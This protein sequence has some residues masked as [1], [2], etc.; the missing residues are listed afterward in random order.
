MKVRLLIGSICLSLFGVLNGQ[1]VIEEAEYFIDTDPGQGNGTAIA[2]PEPNESPVDFSFE[3]PAGEI[4][5][6]DE[7]QHTIGIRFKDDDGEWSVAKFKAFYKQADRAETPDIVAA[8]YYFDTDPGQGNGTPITV[9]TAAPSQEI[10]FD[11]P[12]ETIAALDLGFHKLVI[13]FQDGEGDWSVAMVRTINRV[14]PLSAE[15]TDPKVA[16][17]DYQWLVDGEE[18]GDEQSLTPDEPAKVIAF[19]ELLDLKDLD[20]VT[21]VLRMTPFDTAG[22]MGHPAFHTM[23]IEWLDEENEGAGDGLP[24]AWEDQ[25]EELD[26]TVVNDKNADS[27]NDGLTD[28]EEF[29]A[30]T[31][32]GEPDTD[33]DGINDYSEVILAAYGFD[34]TAD[35]SDL[36]AELQDAAVGA[37]LF[38]TEVQLRDININAPIVARDLAT[39]KI[40]LQIRIQRSSALEETDWTQLPVGSADVAT[41]GGDIKVTLPDQGDDIYFL[42][43]FTDE[44]F[45]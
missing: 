26:S 8:E 34:P 30:G 24:D 18:V 10:S 11:I 29:L 20:G 3:I 19:N 39:G 16:R 32:P 33:A 12:V 37:G 4:D 38:S 7:G 15:Q 14:E 27:D 6:L 41:T 5:A 23:M 28:L 45:Q 43:I 2:V 13:R 40:F 36:L 42:R 22:N 25:F 17:I 1:S 31:D 9:N 44:N 21:A 35:N